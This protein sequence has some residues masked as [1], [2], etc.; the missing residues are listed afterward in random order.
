MNKFMFKSS[1]SIGYIASNFPKAM[2]IFKDYNID[3]CCGGNRPLIDAIKEGGIKEE[4]IMSKLEEAYNNLLIIKD[5]DIDFNVM[6][7]SDLVDYI[8]N[9]HHAYLQIELP[10]IYELTTKILRVH[11]ANHKEP[12]RVHRLFASLKTELEEHLIKEEEIEFPLIKKYES[13]PSNESL[14]KVVSIMEELENEHEGAG[15]ILKELRKITNGYEIPA[16]VCNTF[17]L[18]YQKL[19]ELE[20]DTFQHIHLENNILFPKLKE[21]NNSK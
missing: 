9:T 17:K 12:T 14:A 11:G 21:K 6:S 2:D 18:T 20:A 16:D 15:D 13:D 1:D 10:K 3:F 8:V 4:E 5:K 7:Y 19:Q